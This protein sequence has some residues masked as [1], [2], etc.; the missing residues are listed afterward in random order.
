MTEIADFEE[1]AA[2]LAL[3]A[4]EWNLNNETK[5]ACA[6]R[7]GKIR[8]RIIDIA[9]VLYGNQRGLFPLPDLGLQWERQMARKAG[10][11]QVSLDK[12][13][14]L[15]G[16]RKF[17]KLCCR[18]VTQQVFDPDKFSEARESGDITDSMLASCEIS[19]QYEPRVSLKKLKVE[20]EKTDD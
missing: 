8:E 3:L 1:Y 16:P 10:T 12:L 5:D 11:G 9:N 14:T 13:E 18:R 4:D 19:A 15:L 2:E 6:A 20:K 17:K 7:N